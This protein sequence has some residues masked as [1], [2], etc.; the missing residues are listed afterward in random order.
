MRYLL[1][2]HSNGA[3]I[4][5]YKDDYGKRITHRFIFYP[6]KEAIKLFREQYGLKYK[7]IHIQKLDTEDKK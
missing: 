7:K 6:V 4:I 5:K 3:P 2:Y 1:Y